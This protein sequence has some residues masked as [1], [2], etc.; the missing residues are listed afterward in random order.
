MQLALEMTDDTN[1]PTGVNNIP[2]DSGK[3][4]KTPQEKKKTRVL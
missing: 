3:Q 2:P 1:R 4:K